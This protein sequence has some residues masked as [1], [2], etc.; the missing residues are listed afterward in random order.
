MDIHCS[1]TDKQTDQKTCQNAANSVAS[2]WRVVLKGRGGGGGRSHFQSVTSRDITLCSDHMRSVHHHTGSCLG[3][4]AGS[5]WG[6]FSLIV[7][8][9]QSRTSAEKP[10]ASVRDSKGH[11]EHTHTHTHSPPHSQP[12]TLFQNKPLLLVDKIKRPH[13]DNDVRLFSKD[14]TAKAH[15]LC[16]KRWTLFVLFT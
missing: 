8:G 10:P 12:G 13:H 6:I 5:Q 3:L 14:Q 9:C 4:E 15:E 16:K 11:P 2:E 7:L 1:N